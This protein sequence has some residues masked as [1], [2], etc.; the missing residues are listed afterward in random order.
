MAKKKDE[1]DSNAVFVDSDSEEKKTGVPAV[2]EKRCDVKFSDTKFNAAQLVK[3]RAVKK[4]GLNR[5]VLL[6]LLGD[7]TLT[8]GE[9]MVLLNG[10]ISDKEKANG[11]R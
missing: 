11:R 3:C 5:A 6:A 9:A 8:V 1:T 2:L 4:T 7:K 10:Y